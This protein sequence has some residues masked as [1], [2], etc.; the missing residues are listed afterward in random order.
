MRTPLAAWR[1]GVRWPLALIA[2]VA[3]L[4]VAILACEAIGWPFLVGPI[5]HR[6]EKM[7]DRRVILGGDAQRAS[8][9]RIGLLGSVRVRAASIEI[10]AP[11]WSP[12]PRT[13]LARE[14]NLK[15]GYL[16]LWRAWHGAPLHIASLDAASL[17][18]FLERRADGRASWQFGK[19]K[20]EQ[21]DRAEASLPTFG[22]L[23]VGD[24][25]VL[26]ADEVLPAGID[27]RFALSE[28][29]GPGGEAS[30]RQPAD[31]SSAAGDSASASSAPAAA[32]G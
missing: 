30:V 19:K 10:G 27:A 25:H 22:R 6:L 2:L 24:G 1:A 29:S 3:A 26:Y 15:L 14:A 7:L 16:D 18:A 32:S 28:G 17:D 8:G 9:V 21:A 11:A 12:T 23:I 4:V 5:Q 13:L 31:A 20:D